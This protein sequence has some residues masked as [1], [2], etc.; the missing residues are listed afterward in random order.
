VSAP[1]PAPAFE[2]RQTPD[3][4]EKNRIE[5]EQFCIGGQTQTEAGLVLP[6]DQNGQFISGGPY[7]S[8]PESP[9]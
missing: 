4:K 1:A 9:A 5:P 8:A 2:T 3:E 6:G 7:G